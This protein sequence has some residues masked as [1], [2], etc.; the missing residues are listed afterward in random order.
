MS[1]GHGQLKNSQGPFSWTEGTCVTVQVT[2]GG[3]GQYRG[4][5][6]VH[7]S[8]GT[9]AISVC[10]PDILLLVPVLEGIF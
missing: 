8:P 9:L 1:S 5:C 6:G 4:C 7:P 3:H 2:P 10:L